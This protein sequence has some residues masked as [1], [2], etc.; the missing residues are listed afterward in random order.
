MIRVGLTGGIGSGKS[1]AVAIFKAFDI[2]VFDS[3]SEAKKFLFEDSVKVKLL[4]Y[5]GEKIFTEGEVNRKA[6]AA[7]VFT[8]KKALTFLNSLIH[9]LVRQAIN[10]WFLNHQNYSYSVLEAAVLF[11]YGFYKQVDKIIVV[12]APMNERIRRVMN[13]DGISQE[14]VL[15]RMNNQLLEEEL[16]KRSN[17]VLDNAE[18]DLLLPQILKIHQELSRS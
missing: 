13:R 17:Y 6:L 14:D 18:H 11:E 10:N 12:K 4:T 5:F 2:P 9:P 7:I 16:V 15:Y 3:D 8:D 1:T